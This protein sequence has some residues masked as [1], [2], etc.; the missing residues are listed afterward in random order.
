MWY[1]VS[2]YVL[3]GCIC[4]L[5]NWGSIHHQQWHS[6]F[7]NKDAQ[8]ESH[9]S[10]LGIASSCSKNRCNF[11]CTWLIDDTT[12]SM[13][14]INASMK[15]NR[16]VLFSA[17]H[18]TRRNSKRAPSRPSGILHITN[19]PLHRPRRSGRGSRLRKLLLRSLRRKRFVTWTLPSA[20]WQCSVTVRGRASK[21]RYM[22]SSVLGGRFQITL[23]VYFLIRSLTRPTQF[24]ALPWD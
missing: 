9:H 19:E 24:A 14:L 7:I 2:R 1:H 16:V 11:I 21:R 6:V 15:R 17:L 5:R 8:S 10:I 12:F 18:S 20:T 3:A 23:F 22:S 4:V 13:Y